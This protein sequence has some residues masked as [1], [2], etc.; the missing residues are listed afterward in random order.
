MK[1][2][3]TRNQP[4][5]RPSRSRSRTTSFYAVL[6]ALLTLA[7][8][9]AA[10]FGAR[11]LWP[12][13]GDDDAY[14]QALYWRTL[15]SDTAVEPDHPN[16]DPNLGFKHRPNVRRVIKTPEFEYEVLTNSLGFR[17]GELSP[18]SDGIQR[19]MLLGDSMFEGVG[20]QEDDR[21][22]N[23]LVNLSRS[24]PNGTAVEAYNFAVRGYDTA[25]ALAV[26]R[27]Y[28]AELRPDRV[29]LGFF[30]GNDFVS[31]Y[32]ATITPGGEYRFSDER[33]QQVK[34]WLR[35]T[36]PG[37]LW[38]S[39][40]YRVLN[41]RGLVVRTRY[42]LSVRPE[43]LERSCS[44]IEKVAQETRALD[45]QFD[46]VIFYPKHAVQ[47]GFLA[48]WSASAAAGK[49]V[50]SCARD[51]RLDVVDLIDEISG[52]DDAKKYYWAVDGHL[53]AAGELRLAEIL[54]GHINST[55]AGERV[56][57]ERQN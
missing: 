4:A 40:L 41:L 32:V 24:D 25:Q 11:I 54:W 50:A 2:T 7:V 47:G 28:G 57:I 34:S 5:L 15:N 21:V 53:N 30:V 49:A 29:M 10:E 14:L 38:H 36:H 13:V 19:L 12:Q 27:R 18:S 22:A 56:L 39:R 20:T 46:V 23:Q 37:P 55:R 31:N 42:R 51:R 17:T 9:V 3:E 52:A 6:C 44:W 26:L 35:A 33:I 43:G 48:W 16:F 1:N 45:A 8:I